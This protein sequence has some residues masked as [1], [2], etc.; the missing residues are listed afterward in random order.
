VRRLKK[1][2]KSFAT[3]AQTRS[4]AHGGKHGGT[5]GTFGRGE[6]PAELE[7]GLRAAAGETSDVVQSPLGY[8]VLRGG[9]AGGREPDRSFPP[10]PGRRRASVLLR[11]KS[12]MS[13]REFVQADGPGQGES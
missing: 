13:V 1:D 11:Q 2:P 9:G 8:H 5:M 3:L 6:L 7:R 10:V 4:R 12:D